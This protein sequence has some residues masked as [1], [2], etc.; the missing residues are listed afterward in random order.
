MMIVL[1]TRVED[2]DRVQR[3]L[4]RPQD[5]LWPVQV[6]R[7]FLPTRD[8][9]RSATAVIGVDFNTSAIQKAT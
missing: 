7:G 5:A 3:L 9:A 2:R 8:G 6:R 1:T 4:A